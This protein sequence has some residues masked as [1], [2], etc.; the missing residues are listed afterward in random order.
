MKEKN[1][2]KKGKKRRKILQQASYFT[3]CRN[4]K[5]LCKKHALMLTTDQM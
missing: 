1:L 4:N 3:L 2:L 5:T